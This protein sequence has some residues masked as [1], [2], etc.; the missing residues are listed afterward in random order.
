MLSFRQHPATWAWSN[1][2]HEGGI[3]EAESSAE[4][5]RNVWVGIFREDRAKADGTI[6]QARRSVVLGAVKHV[7]KLQAIE[8][9][10]P[11]S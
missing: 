5:K 2:C 8:A 3:R 7:T 1:L 6:R 9:L 4:E 10:R 11:V